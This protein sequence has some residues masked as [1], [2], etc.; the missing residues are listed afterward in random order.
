MQRRSLAGRLS[1][2]RATRSGA[3]RSRI[4]TIWTRTAADD[5]AAAQA[6]TLQETLGDAPAES[7]RNQDS[8]KCPNQPNKVRH[9]RGG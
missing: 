3:S 6:D 1:L 4:I 7:L 8:K 9:E 2:T 5:A